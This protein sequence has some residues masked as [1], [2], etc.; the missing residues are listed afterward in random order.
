MDR[1]A[2]TYRFEAKMKEHEWQD[3]QWEELSFKGYVLVDCEY[4]AD[5]TRNK[6]FPLGVRVIEIATN[7][8]VYE[9][10]ELGFTDRINGLTI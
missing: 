4:T 3:A 6:L 10:K 7:K 9:A 8:V 2:P 1:P 5:H